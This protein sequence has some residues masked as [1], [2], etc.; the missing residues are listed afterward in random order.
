M[1]ARWRMLVRFHAGP[2]GFV[3]VRACDA[4]LVLLFLLNAF[5]MCNIS[6]VGHAAPP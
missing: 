1:P 3:G 5:V 6:G 4:T 2:V